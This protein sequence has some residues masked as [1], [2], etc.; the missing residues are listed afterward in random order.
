MHLILYIERQTSPEGGYYSASSERLP[1]S[2]CTNEIRVVDEFPQ[3]LWDKVNRG[4][5]EHG[6]DGTLD[7]FWF[8]YFDKAR[9]IWRS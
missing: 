6:K 1:T 9:I 7:D 2:I 8:P 4:E 3:E 5:I